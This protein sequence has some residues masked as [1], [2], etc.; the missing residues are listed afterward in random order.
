M[1]TTSFLVTQVSSV[2]SHFSFNHSIYFSLSTY[3]K[4]V[5]SSNLECNLSLDSQPSHLVFLFP[6]FHCSYPSC[7]LFTETSFQK[8]W[9]IIASPLWPTSFT[10][11]DHLPHL[12]PWN[13]VQ[14]IFQS[15]SC[16]SHLALTGH[17]PPPK[18][19]HTFLPT[20]TF[21]FLLNTLLTVSS[22]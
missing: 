20:T 16:P 8:L 1:G 19:L 12:Y 11:G 13:K 14:S 17:C 18:P 4:L 7:T 6:V 21:F 10:L 2:E 9:T 3:S 22:T 15:M 5:H